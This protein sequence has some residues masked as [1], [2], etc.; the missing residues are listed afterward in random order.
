MKLGVIADDFTGAV[1]IAGFLVEGGMQTMMC[2]MPVD[3]QDLG[4]VDAIVMSLKIR[5]IPAKHAVKEALNALA[6]LQQAGC[7]RFYYKYCST[8]DSTKEGNIGPVT[9]ALRKALGEKTTLICPALPINGRTVFHG[10]LFVND[11]LLN[12]S[13]MRHHPLNPM[14]D[15]KLE[16]LIAMQ[17]SSKCGHIF[18]NA[19]AKGVVAVQQKREALENEGVENLIVDV[20]DD[21]DLVTIAEA[22]KDMRLVTG[23]SGLAIGMAK[24]RAKDLG[25]EP[26][27]KP[28]FIPKHDKAVVLAGS[29]SAMMQKQ[30]EYYRNLAPSLSLDEELCVNDPD[31]IESVAKWVLD[32]QHLGLAPLVYATRSPEQ[33]EKNRKIFSGIDLAKIIEQSFAA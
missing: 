16:R 9:D 15:A 4:S 23:G 8:F 2:S 33:L 30:V 25:L 11:D 29:C 19:V 31:Y 10:Y 18:Y 22:T 7:N 5:S 26:K 1:D 24:V 6:F 14:L 17:S 28:A 27:Q 12:D 13:A 21:E 32:H 3:T 20:I